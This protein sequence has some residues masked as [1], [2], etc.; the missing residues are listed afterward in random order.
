MH[1]AAFASLGLDYRYLAFRVRS[2]DLATA[3]RSIRVLGIRGVNVTVPHKERVARFVDSVS[4]IAAAIGAVNTIVNDGGHLHGDNTDVFGFVQSLRD[5]RRRLRGRR[6]IVIGAGG[7]SRA[8]LAGLRHIGMSEVLLANRTPGRARTL[9]ARIGRHAPP[10]RVVSLSDLSAAS[11]FDGV[12]LVVN[13]TSLGWRGER[14]PPI[15]MAAS[16]PRCIYY[17]MAYG[18]ATDFLHGA[19]RSNRPRLDGSEML[20]FQGARAFTLWTKRRAPIAAMRKALHTQIS[21]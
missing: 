16:D 14:F 12:A 5:H 13:A 1:N 11:M 19:E 9:L 6:A 8:V 7:A 10:C 3:T 2:D 20:I 15:A 4:E 17:D 21:N 18:R